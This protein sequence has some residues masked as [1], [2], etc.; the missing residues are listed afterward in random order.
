ML[1]MILSCIILG[2]LTFYIEKVFPGEFG[3]AMPWYFFLEP[4]LKLC[5]KEREAFVHDE[6]LQTGNF[7]NDFEDEPDS[8]TIGIQTNK[9]TK[10]FGDKVA[11][12]NL[13]LNMY[14]DQIT[15]LLGHNG[16]GDTF[17]L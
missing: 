8:M 15:V 9:L 10:V 6:L 5:H 16:A 13:T 14:E 2:L 4:I 17:L 3:I 12:N 7:N 11:V 1:F